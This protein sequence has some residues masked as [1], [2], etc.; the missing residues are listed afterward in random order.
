MGV[1]PYSEVFTFWPVRL[2]RSKH[3]RLGGC[4]RSRNKLQRGVPSAA[5]VKK[6]QRVREL[7]TCICLLAWPSHSTLSRYEWISS[8]QVEIVVANFNTLVCLLERVIRIWVF[9]NIYDPSRSVLRK[10]DKPCISL[11]YAC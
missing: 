1:E 3:P 9:Q 10:N 8:N 11:V 7:E 4:R 6:R 5:L 2:L